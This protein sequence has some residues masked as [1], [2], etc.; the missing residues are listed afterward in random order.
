[1]KNTKEYATIK[2][3]NSQTIDGVTKKTENKFNCE[4]YKRDE[5]FY[6]TYNKDADAGTDKLR[7][8]LKIQK[9]AITIRRMGN[10]KSV[11]VFQEN[12]V[13][14]TLYST[15]FGSIDMKISTSR[16]VNGLSDE[17]GSIS[18]K[19]TLVM[20]DENIE[21]DIHVEIKKEQKI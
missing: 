21:N 11:M 4:F 3:V 13:T 18:I 5:S 17:G 8:F 7:V 1:M 15:P 19:Y 2:I 20:G 16:I 12:K 10:F 14:D 9:S 6:I